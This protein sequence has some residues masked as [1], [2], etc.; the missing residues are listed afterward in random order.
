MLLVTLVAPAAIA[1]NLFFK[2]LVKTL[3]STA[4]L[5]NALISAA[6]WSP[7]APSSTFKNV[8]TEAALAVLWKSPLPDCLQI[9]P[10]TAEVTALSVVFI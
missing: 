8:L 6:V 9:N 2:A 3:E 5:T 7:V 10:D 4:A 1:S